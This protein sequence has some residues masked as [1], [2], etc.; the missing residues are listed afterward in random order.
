MNGIG[1]AFA[2]LGVLEAAQCGLL[3]WLLTAVWDLKRR[4]IV[5]EINLKRHLGAQW[6][7]EAS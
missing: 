1:T 4:Q 5:L 7:D 3:L 6:T 2:I